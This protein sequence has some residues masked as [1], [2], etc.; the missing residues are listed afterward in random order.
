[1]K[2]LGIHNPWNSTMKE[3]EERALAGEPDPS[4]CRNHFAK[5]CG[6]CP[7]GN[8]ELWCNSDC[9][10]RKLG[11]KDEEVE[12]DVVDGVDVL[13]EKSICVSK[14]IQCRATPLEVNTDANTA[15]NTLT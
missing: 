1:M 5:T 14:E 15:N 6:Q 2:L 4:N 7:Q 9:K 13:S 10:W 3:D 11:A 12:G 8:G